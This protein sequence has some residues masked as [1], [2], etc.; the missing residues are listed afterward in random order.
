MLNSFL[1]FLEEPNAT[2]S[3]II[4]ATNHP[5]L[6]DRA[7][8]RRFDRTLQYQL[9]D[10]QAI[11]TL[12]TQTLG[13]FRPKTLV[14]DKI[15]AS[16]NSLSLAGISKAVQEAIKTAI[17]DEKKVVSVDGLVSELQDRLANFESYQHVR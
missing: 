9:P 15:I 1:Q 3:L 4:A 6:L 14:W 7:L 16:S 5:E 13:S 2:D 10:D 12:V 17:L 8:F 11:K